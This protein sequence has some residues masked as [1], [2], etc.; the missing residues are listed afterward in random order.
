MKT[1]ITKLVFKTVGMRTRCYVGI[2]N[3]EKV[4]DATAYFYEI[5]LPT[6]AKIGSNGFGPAIYIN[7]V[8][9]E[10]KAQ[11]KGFIIENDDFDSFPCKSKELD[12]QWIDGNWKKTDNLEIVPSYEIWT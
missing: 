6:S 1:I 11:K 7:N 12:I 3:I 10:P 2:P 4:P 9:F 8:Y 5:D